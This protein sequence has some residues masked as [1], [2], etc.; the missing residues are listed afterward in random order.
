[1][2]LVAEPEAENDDHVALPHV[3]L[4]NVTEAIIE[5]IRYSEDHADNDTSIVHDAINDNE[6]VI[7]PPK[8]RSKG[9]PKKGPFTCDV[10][11]R[12]EQ[13]LCRLKSHIKQAHGE[14]NIPCPFDYC[15]SK[16][17]LKKYLNEHLKYVHKIL[18]R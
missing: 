6:Q 18:K 17:A 4:L 7:E 5:E 15:P 10:C 13:H 1:M 16:F 12:V 3:P 9:A 14:R 11:G 8:K 2:S